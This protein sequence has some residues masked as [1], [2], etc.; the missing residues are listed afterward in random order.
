MKNMFKPIF[1]LAAMLASAFAPSA[2]AAEAPQFEYFLPDGFQVTVVLNVRQVLDAPAFENARDRLISDEI[3][4]FA[5]SFKAMT[6]VDPLKD[7]NELLFAGYLDDS[8]KKDQLIML[9]GKMEVPKRR[10]SPHVK[11]VHGAVKPLW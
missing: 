3:R 11:C 1:L 10:G 9:R 8:R 2:S 4:A 5:E 7:L 6:S